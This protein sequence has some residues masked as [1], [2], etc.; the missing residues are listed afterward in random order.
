MGFQQCG[1]VESALAHGRR[2]ALDESQG[3]FQP[4]P[5]SD[6]MILLNEAKNV[7]PGSL[8]LIGFVWDLFCQ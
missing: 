7:S 5:F 1:Q 4:S 6:L 2:L 3:P 8:V